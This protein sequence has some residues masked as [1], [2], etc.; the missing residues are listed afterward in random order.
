[1]VTCTIDW[2]E[3]QVFPTADKSCHYGRKSNDRQGCSTDQ[4]Q[5]GYFKLYRPRYQALVV[6]SVVAGHRLWAGAVICGFSANTA[7]GREFIVGHPSFCV[8]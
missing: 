4:S 2:S 5:D 1:M 3:R 6:L 7:V 8:A